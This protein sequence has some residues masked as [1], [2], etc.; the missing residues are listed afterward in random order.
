MSGVF[1][2]YI[3][4]VEDPAARPGARGGPDARSGLGA[5]G[6][7]SRAG[8]RRSRPA[9]IREVAAAA[10]V[11]PTT[12]SHALNGM[13]RLSEATR[14]HVL[15]VAARL[16]YRANPSARNMRSG[17]SGIIAVINQ[18]SHGASFQASDLEYIMRLNQA[19]CRAAWDADCYP[20]LL[21][22][23]VD[24]GFLG[25]IPLDGAILADPLRRDGTLRALDE[26]GIPAVTVG[27]D[28]GLAADRQWWA[29]NDIAAATQ[30][31][32]DHLAAAGAQRICLVSADTGQS[33][34]T[35]AVEAYRRWCAARGVPTRLH[36]LGTPFSAADC[37]AAV[38]GECAGPDPADALYLVVEALVRPALDAVAEAGLGIPD[39]MQVV[40]ASDSAVA[41]FGRPTLTAVDLHPEEIGAAAVGL[42]ASRLAGDRARS[43]LVAASLVARGSTRAL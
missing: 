33:Y 17:A 6:G 23:G 24:A 26:L 28:A 38:S 21:P 12:V 40:V 27:R 37:F 1:R 43:A 25:R 16:E 13:G 4:E 5:R 10:G 14:Q 15:D 30:T 42:L 35:D 32:L 31:A 29:D 2:D 11:S 22:P 34:M 36:V 19:I 9:G 7:P 8:G 18:L 20:T 39:Q 3:G 41:R